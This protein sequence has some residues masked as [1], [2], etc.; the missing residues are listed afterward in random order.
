[1]SANG[2]RDVIVIGAGIGGL[3]AAAYLARAGLKVVVLEAGNAPG[4]LAAAPPLGAEFAVPAGAPWLQALDPRIVRDL[5]LA[6]RGLRFAVRDMPLVGLRP[7]GRHVVV[8]R[9]VHATARALAIHSKADGEAWTRLRRDWEKL[10]RALRPHWWGDGAVPAHAGDALARLTR[11]GAAA[12]LDGRF[13]SDAVKS[14]LGVAA[15]A[16]G[17]SPLEPGSALAMLW[18]DAQE[19]CGFQGA[20]AIPRGGPATLVQALIAAAKAEGADIRTGTE[21][22]AILTHGNAVAGVELGN[23]ERIAAPRVVSNLSRRRTLCDLLPAAEA[24]FA[25]ARL[26]DDHRPAVGAAQVLLALDHLPVFGGIAT[27]ATARFVI[28]E[29]MEALA[30]AHAQAR[31]GHLPHDL[32]LMFALPS[33]ADPLLAPLGQHV[34]SA[35]VRPVPL[36]PARGWEALKPMLRDRVLAALARHVPD[37]ARHVTRSVVLTPADFHALSGHEDVS[38]SVEHMLSGWDARIDTPLAGLTLCG[39]DAEPVPCASGRAGRIAAAK[40][41][42]EKLS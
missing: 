30:A 32:S 2:N 13:E 42:K 12:F 1:M 8:T 20:A 14:T 10:A 21:A 19:M 33:A 18:H 24:G 11:T 28:A 38:S 25:A 36:A 6:K 15:L 29:R 39:A 34:L 3:T 7:D 40:I 27:S 37:I 5:K 17:L 31:A 16:S 35:V 4:G 9:D 41:V 26:C 22:V 23:G